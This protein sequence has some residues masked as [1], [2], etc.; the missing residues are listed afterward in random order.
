MAPRAKGAGVCP[1]RAGAVLALGLC[2]IPALEG[3]GKRGSPRPPLPRGP[4]APGEV[5]ARQIGRR[6]FVAFDVPAAKG[7]RP[8]QQPVRAQLVRVTYEPDFQP[9]ADPDAFRRR[10]D[11][12][13]EIVADPL[14][15]EGRLLL[16][17]LRLHEL[18]Q[19]GVGYT[20]RYAVRVSDRRGRSS[21]LVVSP[22]LEL[23]EPIA[24]PR[25]LVAEPTA[26]GVRLRW[27]APQ[28]GGDATYNVYRTR[29]EEPWP[30]EPLNR[31]PLPAT[32]YLDAS[33]STGERYAYTVRASLAA[34]RP[35]REGDPS[36]LREVLAEDRFP[37]IAP[38]GLVAVQ[39]GPAVRLFWD[40]NPE[41][42]LAGYRVERQVEDGPWVEVGPGTTETPSFLDG[43]V[44]VGWRVAYRILAL[45]RV[46]PPN[47]SPPSSS[48]ELR[49]VPEPVTPGPAQP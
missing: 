48:V 39:E 35:F 25:D 37:P 1:L 43:G 38:R 20:L 33:V 11:V 29:P 34:E 2:V 27:S 5:A 23:L 16:E 30:D 21:P 18:P 49:V 24:A 14:S 10:G 28:G 47:I 32:D 40:P 41:R 12:V 45:D 6:A 44:E 19:H 46:D 22:D 42:D 8:S 7:E 31:Q 13:G 26:D 4:S 17:D 3:C 15:A 9:P 36:E